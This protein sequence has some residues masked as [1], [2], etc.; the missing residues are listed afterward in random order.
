MVNVCWSA[1][2]RKKYRGPRIVSI[3]ILE[4]NPLSLKCEKCLEMVL[5]VRK[6]SGNILSRKFFT[7]EFEK[8]VKAIQ[9]NSI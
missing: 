5:G 8:Q 1:R 3:K 9:L 6:F 7:P 2:Q 4:K